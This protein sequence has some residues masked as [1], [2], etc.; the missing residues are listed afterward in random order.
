MTPKNAWHFI[1][2][3]NVF[4]GSVLANTTLD[5]GHADGWN[6][7]LSLLNVGLYEETSAALWDPDVL[8]NVEKST[9]LTPSWSLV[10]GTQNGA[11]F[12]DAHRSSGV[13]S[14]SYLDNQFTVGAAGVQLHLGGYVASGLMTG[15]GDRAGYIVGAQIPL[16]DPRWVLSLDYISGNNALGA[17]AIQLLWRFARQWRLDVGAQIPAINSPNDYGALLGLAWQP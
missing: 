9:P 2:E 1:E 8:L 5:Y 14:Y 11:A 17:G 16:P 7:G 15:P 4:A 12:W 10:L 13:E 3:L 6:I